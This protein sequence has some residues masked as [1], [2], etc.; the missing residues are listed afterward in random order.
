MRLTG[1][2]AIVDSGDSGSPVFRTMSGSEV[3]LFGILWG[4]LDEK[5]CE[6]AVNGDRELCIPR[7]A[8]CP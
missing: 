8:S 5:C 1:R 3:E 6:R 2:G 7:T 4:E